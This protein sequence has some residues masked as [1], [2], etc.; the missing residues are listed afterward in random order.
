MS[1]LRVRDL[2]RKG[3]FALLP[4]DDLVLARRLMDGWRVRH[5][6]VVEEDG[7]VVGILSHRD[8]LRHTLLGRDG[9]SEE[10]LEENLRGM[11]A[12]EIM[13]VHVETV[14]PDAPL[15]E[16]A[17]RMYREKLG[18]LVV[19]DGRGRL[20]GILTE[21]DFV[22]HH[23]PT[24]VPMHD[25]GRGFALGALLGLAGGALMGILYAPEEGKK[26][27]KELARRGEQ[28]SHR[29]E[30]VLESASGWVEKGRQR[31]GV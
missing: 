11:A 3:V 29:A 20:A 17:D 13:S 30:N 16:A 14:R 19:V 4:D 12:K 10:E 1:V 24:E 8:L 5:A 26:T 25:W 22:R 23:F 6:P 28:L 7:S 21:A 27:R 18:C 9:V 31:I 2:M 15:A